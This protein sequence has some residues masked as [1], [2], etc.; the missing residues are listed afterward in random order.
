MR[1]IITIGNVQVFKVAK[2]LS[3]AIDKEA[4]IERVFRILSFCLHVDKPMLLFPDQDYRLDC[5]NVFAAYGNK[6]LH[7]MVRTHFQELD[8]FYLWE[9]NHIVKP[10]RRLESDCNLF[11]VPYVESD[12][13]RNVLSPLGIRY[14]LAAYLKSKGRPIAVICCF[15]S[16]ELPDFSNEEIA[17]IEA[18]APYL[19]QVL[20]NLLVFQGMREEHSYLQIMENN[21]SFGMMVV[22]DSMEVLWANKTADNLFKAI[23]NDGLSLPSILC[24]DA[25]TLTDC[26]TDIGLSKG[27]APTKRRTIKLS[28]GENFAIDLE[29]VSPQGTCRKPMFRVDMKQIKELAVDHNVLSQKYNLSNREIEVAARATDGLSNQQ[30]GACLFISEITVKKHLQRIFD[31]LGVNSRAGLIRR[32]VDLFNGNILL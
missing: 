15:R 22:S 24:E 1:P 21:P 20:S 2:Y 18:L 19:T 4:F 14:E 25:R 12:H 16:P 30:I 26:Q 23:E 27:L 29:L 32:M 7:M 5:E 3:G 28:T 8:P 9:K 31:K 11:A 13:Y 10:T 17:V 6:D